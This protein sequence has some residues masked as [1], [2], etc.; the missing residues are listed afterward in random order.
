[1]VHHVFCLFS[2]KVYKTGSILYSRS[3]VDLATLTLH[4]RNELEARINVFLGKCDHAITDIQKLKDQVKLLSLPSIYF[5]S[6]AIAFVL[7]VISIKMLAQVEYIIHINSDYFIRT[8]FT[9]CDNNMKMLNESFTR[10]MYSN[11]ILIL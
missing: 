5:L 6:F 3:F 9:N 10:D 11:Q 2:K 7:K 4:R 8:H 1:M